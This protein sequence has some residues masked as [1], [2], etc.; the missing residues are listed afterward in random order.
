M[1]T[2]PEM[3][4]GIAAALELVEARLAAAES[5]LAAEQEIPLDDLE[6]CV[7]VLCRA[8][9]GVD[10]AA[11]AAARATLESLLVRLDA[12]E[13]AIAGKAAP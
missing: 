5:A 12:L 3:P 13:A 2:A 9:A 1:T 7:D 11:R 8:S 4:T 10:D 6:T